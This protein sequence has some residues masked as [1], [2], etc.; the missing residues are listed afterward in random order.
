MVVSQ[1]GSVLGGRRRKRA[2]GAGTTS[3]MTLRSAVMMPAALVLATVAVGCGGGSKSTS[4][5]KFEQA[6]LNP[7][8][9]GPQ[10][11]GANRWLPLKRGTQWVWLG[12]TEVEH[13]AVPHLVVS[14]VT[15]VSRT[16]AGV[17]TILVLEVVIN[18]GQVAHESLSYLAEDSHR[19]VWDLGRYGEAQPG[20]RFTSVTDAWLA[21]VNGALAG[22][23]M[24][25]DP[26]PGTT[27]WVIAKPPGADAEVAEAVQ[28][29][30][31]HC[32]PSRCY[33]GVLV[34]R[35]GTTKAPN[36]EL[37]YY[38]PGIGEIDN[39]PGP[40]SI[41]KDVEKL[42]SVM[43]VSSRRVP[44]VR[45][46]ALKLDAHARTTTPSVFAPGAP[47]HRIF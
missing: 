46:E 14:T 33:S 5:G 28:T 2:T 43:P 17:P 12:T 18:S 38:A 47:A 16:V 23:L 31:S 45:A 37:K 9:F 34:L 41:H 22:I 40:A 20:G 24:P 1:N 15:D 11:V 42:S 32:V 25:A 6:K 8:R 29:G 10:V 27:P 21:G 36:M 7:A 30:Q 39:V 4:T 26:H 3:G 19:D 35:Q 44:E 13:R